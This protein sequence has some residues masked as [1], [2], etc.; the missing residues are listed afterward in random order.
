MVFAKKRKNYEIDMLNGPLLGKILR[1]SF[2]LLLTNVLQLLYN[3][4]DLIIIGQFS[5]SETSVAAVGA[6]GSLTN[7]IV[8]LFVGLSVGVSVL[9]AKGYGTGDR[10]A[11]QQTVH[12]AMA[13]SLIS[14]FIVLIAG[15]F[16]SRRFLEWMDTSPAIIEQSTLY[17]MIFFAGAPFNM[18]YNFGASILRA[19]GDTKRPLYFLAFSGFVN[20]VLNFVFVYFFSMDVAGVALATVISQLIS[21]VLIVMSLRRQE[22]MCHLYIR[23]LRIHKDILLCIIQIGLPASIQS[24]LFSI[25]NIL[26]Q[27]SVNSF[28]L[29]FASLGKAPYTSGSAA[30]GNIEGFIYTSINSFQHASMNFTGQ[31]YAAKKYERVRKILYTCTLSAVAVGVIA[32]AIAII[33]GKSLLSF[34]IPGNE[35]AITY[36]Y[37]RLLL[38]SAT[39]FLCGIME[40]LVG[41]LRGLGKSLVPMFISVLGIC[42]FRVFW[43]YTVFAISRDWTTLFIS[44]PVSWILT[45]ILQFICYYLIQKKMPKKDMPSSA[46][47]PVSAEA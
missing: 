41:Q 43:I 2:S 14:G 25:S 27:S 7:L 45:S 28:D 39:Y 37:Q 44:Y 36:G 38:L 12:T 19:T 34:Y 22:G 29:A 1:F 30:A 24:M 13:L 35:E 26:I 33:F 4:A 46:S 47:A 6:T 31:N 5:G 9:V 20:V 42:A 18:V 8:N 21:S 3:A 11:T 16:L 17:L 23:K 40:V 15:M 32:G 10:K